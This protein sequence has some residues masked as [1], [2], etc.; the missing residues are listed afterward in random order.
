M[1]P[2]RYII[3]ILFLFVLPAM[4]SVPPS[5]PIVL[6]EGE[7][8]QTVTLTAAQVEAI[9]SFS[10]AYK[11]QAPSADVNA[12]GLINEVDVQDFTSALM[13]ELGFM[14]VPDDPSAGLD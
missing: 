8:V 7:Q 2:I 14:V 10:V 4:A 5:A 12:D 13:L 1:V 11:T 6:V 9:N 3:A